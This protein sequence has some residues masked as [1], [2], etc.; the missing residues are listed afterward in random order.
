MTD[1]KKIENLRAYEEDEEIVD[2]VE[3]ALRSLDKAP[4]I[5]ADQL[6]MMANA[7]LQYAGF[8]DISPWIKN[9]WYV[10]AE[11]IENY[12]SKKLH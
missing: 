12:E 5:I 8:A 10:A 3:M 1:Y 6:R 9:I 11:L 7:E 2:A 4:Q